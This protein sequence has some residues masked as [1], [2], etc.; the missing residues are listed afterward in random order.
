[1]E[2]NS[3]ADETPLPQTPEAHEAAQSAPEAAE[4]AP[5]AAS[6]EGASKPEPET[7]PEPAP[8][9]QASPEP[10]PEAAEPTETATSSEPVKAAES[11]AGE[12]A[13]SREASEPTAE[14]AHAETGELPFGE[15]DA[16]AAEG[17]ATPGAEADAD[18]LVALAN[19][20]LKGRLS[21]AD[22]ERTAALLKAA[23]LEGRKGVEK[24][25]EQL[26]KLPWVIG[27]NGV[28]AAWPDMKTTIRARLIGGLAKIDSDAARR[29][30]LSLARGLFKQD[31]PAA[32]KLATGV[33][34]E[35]RDKETGAVQPKN[36][37]IFANVLIG[38]AKPWIGQVA[39]A[40]LKP[41]D[42]DLLVHCALL[43]VFSMPHAPAT[44]LGVIKWAVAAERLGKIQPCVLE[45]II[46]GVSRWSGKWQG[47]LRK[48]VTPL[49]EEIL[50][51]LK[52][53]A[54][55]A[56]AQQQQPREK[57]RRE[58]RQAKGGEETAVE[59]EEAEDREEAVDEEAAREPKGEE[60]E[61]RDEEE[62][63][64]EE[65]DREEDEEE[66]AAAERGES[67]SRR[68]QQQKQRP[69]YE[70]KTV[71][72]PQGR[73]QQG[74]FNLSETLRQIESHVA[75]L[76]SELNSTQ[77]KLRQREDELRKPRRQQDRQ[78]TTIVPGEPS[79]EE[80]A[81]LNRQLETR[82]AELVEHLQELKSDS[83]DRAASLAVPDAAVSPDAPLRTLLAFKLQ[84]DFEDFI[85]LEKE[86]PDIVV[87][88]HY[89]TVLRHVF[90]V[91]RA[92]GVKLV[93]TPEP[94]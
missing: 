2:P 32:M 41:A 49:P 7:T 46:K 66:E 64:D 17:A 42:A 19:Q 75:S 25:V 68:Q 22:E 12:P 62:D 77:N 30:R 87:Q 80:L 14:A 4:P 39:L 35:M 50:A 84:E 55:E 38:R 47:A 57:A 1:M 33:A 53:P 52:T 44:Q 94:H 27:V 76:R 70:S 16:T 79:L 9:A 23:L 65:V 58:D 54:P 92:E 86:A 59:D 10:A 18:P 28:T 26:P 5:A 37:Q 20:A 31:I 29:V 8:A 67:G 40:D 11:S 48:E 81:R 45:A 90:E 63:E 89:R 43:S 21:P 51:A 85:A 34:K 61:D 36:A 24:A 13:P 73:R 71:P 69:V 3:Q 6:A 91:L 74:G 88:Q 82:N 15:T 56:P 83:E 60:D 78:P 93:E 72:Q